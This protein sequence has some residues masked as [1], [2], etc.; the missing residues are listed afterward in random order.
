MKKKRD[1]KPGIL[2]NSMVNSFGKQVI[3]PPYLYVYTYLCMC[4]YTSK[5]RFCNIRL[6]KSE[7]VPAFKGVDI[8]M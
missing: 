4:M 3:H 5:C 7:N 1:E 2:R 8:G 6:V